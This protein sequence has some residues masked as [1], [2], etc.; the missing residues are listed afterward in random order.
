MEREMGMK[1]KY[2]VKQIQVKEG[3]IVDIQLD[4]ILFVAPVLYSIPRALSIEYLE[5]I[6]EEK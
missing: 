6:K 2:E 1:K 4:H 5:E 3:D